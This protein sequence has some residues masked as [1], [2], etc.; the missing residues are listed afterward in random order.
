VER[1][2]DGVDALIYLLDYTKLKTVE[3]ASVLARLRSINPALVQRL[4][5][6]LFFVVNK[7]DQAEEGQGLGAGDTRAYVA[8]LVTRQMDCPG[9]SLHPD[10]VRRWPAAGSTVQVLAAALLR[11][12]CC[13]WPLPGC[14]TVGRWPPCCPAVPL[15][16][17]CWESAG[18][19][20]CCGLMHQHDTT[21]SLMPASP[22]CL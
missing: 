19:T 10:Q 12:R 21:S 15:A 5:T 14:C 13:C 1:L 3:E 6:R 2:L 18:G 17:G 11:L 22:S 20:C 16:V 9:F 7:F 4:S 8:E